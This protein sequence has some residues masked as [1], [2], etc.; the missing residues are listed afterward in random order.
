MNP[1]TIVLHN[2]L[3]L[4]TTLQTRK[5][6]LQEIVTELAAGEVSDVGRTWGNE[7]REAL[8][9]QSDFKSLDA[10]LESLN[11]IAARQVV[12]QGL[13]ERVRTGLEEFGVEV[14]KPGVNKKILAES[15]RA[16]AEIL[17]WAQNEK[18]GGSEIL[19]GNSPNEKELEAEM[20]Q[21][22]RQFFGSDLTDE[23]VQLL[24]RN[25]VDGFISLIVSKYNSAPA[26]N[27]PSPQS[28]NATVGSNDNA[29]V[30]SSKVAVSL[31]SVLAE[32]ALSESTI[33]GLRNRF[34]DLLTKSSNSW[35]QLQTSLG[36]DQSR[37]S[38]EVDFGKMQLDALETNIDAHKRADPMRLSG[39]MDQLS[40]QI[41]AS[42][43]I[44]SR[45]QNMSL[46]K[47][48]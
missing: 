45:L 23:R 41:E 31:I 6:R 46:A 34:V 24:S 3:L 9:R 11:R 20:R 30:R 40:A 37:L 16:G 22:F 43:R 17:T 26:T 18:F 33:D 1:M 15:S 29:V 7:S 14:L 2:G 5:Q 44:I 12:A 25:E 38:T 19:A 10:T 32:S 13:M 47:F 39:E 27:T 48:L 8:Q 36:R 35:R 21:Q 4:E 28:A 42:Y